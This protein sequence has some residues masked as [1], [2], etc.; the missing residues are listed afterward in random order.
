MMDVRNPV[1]LAFKTL[2]LD[3][4]ALQSLENVIRSDHDIIN[5]IN[6]GQ[7]AEPAWF[8]PSCDVFQL[9][10]TVFV[11]EV[12]HNDVISVQKWAHIFVV[13]LPKSN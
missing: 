5:V 13:G 6:A 11:A 12:C 1:W 3:E 10:S 4:L 7:D 8:E 2:N 9:V